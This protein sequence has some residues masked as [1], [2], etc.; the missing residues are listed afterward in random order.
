[1]GESRAHGADESIRLS[2]AKA[3]VLE[4]IYILCAPEIAP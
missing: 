1:M 4:L 3:H 2:D